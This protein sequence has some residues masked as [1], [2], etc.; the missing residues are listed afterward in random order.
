[1]KALKNQVILSAFVLNEKLQHGM[2][3]QSGIRIYGIGTLRSEKYVKS[4]YEAE[5][6]SCA[7][8]YPLATN[9]IGQTLFGFKETWGKGEYQFLDY[10]QIIDI[11]REEGMET[12]QMPSQ[13]NGKV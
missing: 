3:F 12:Y 4:A 8:I 6:G 1:M 13:I 7:G 5:Y 10:S 9:S 11:C 2:V